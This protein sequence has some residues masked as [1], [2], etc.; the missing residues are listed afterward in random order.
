MKEVERISSTIGV[1]KD[2]TSSG[3]AQVDNQKPSKETYVEVCTFE[4][5]D[6]MTRFTKK[7]KVENRFGLAV[8]PMCSYQLY[9]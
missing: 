5:T 8:S 1:S 2:R 3:K 6:S 9:L 7:H 4:Y